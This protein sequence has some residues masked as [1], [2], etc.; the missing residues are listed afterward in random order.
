MC[1]LS[2]TVE[3]VVEVEAVVEAAEASLRAAEKGAKHTPEN[4]T[5]R[6]EPAQAL[7]D[8]LTPSAPGLTALAGLRSLRHPRH[9]SVR[10]G[11]CA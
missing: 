8:A 7:P 5:P 11:D 10:V 4:R 2:M 6:T 9:H 1:E 3:P